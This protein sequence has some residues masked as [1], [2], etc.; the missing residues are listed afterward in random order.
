MK[1]SD[2]QYYNSLLNSGVD[3]LKRE[4]AELESSL[5][6][7]VPLSV[8]V[9]ANRRAAMVRNLLRLTQLSTTDRREA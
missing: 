3:E 1:E 6:D 7:S 8:V 9:T 4:L 2:A 5:D